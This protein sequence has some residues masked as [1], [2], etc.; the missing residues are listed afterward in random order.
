MSILN[1]ETAI[2]ITRNFPNALY[3]VS[4]TAFPSSYVFPDFHLNLNT[5]IYNNIACDNNYLIIF[6]DI[7]Y[8][9]ITNQQV[10]NC[11]FFCVFTPV[12]STPAP[13]EYQ[14]WK[15]KIPCRRFL[16]IDNPHHRSTASYCFAY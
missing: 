2:C 10:L 16:Q 6:D 9:S 3:F 12:L 13:S 15:Y 8:I 7:C 11:T 4:C 1:N 5:L 14:L